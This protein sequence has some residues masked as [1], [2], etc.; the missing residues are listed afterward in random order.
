MCGFLFT[1]VQILRALQYVLQALSEQLQ[2]SQPQV[3]DIG[4]SGQLTAS[5]R[6]GQTGL[7][8]DQQTDQLLVNLW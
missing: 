5:L 6:T 1:S 3:G 8:I 4:V 7:R 2:E